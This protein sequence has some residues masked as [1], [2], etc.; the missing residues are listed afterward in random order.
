MEADSQ[1]CSNCKR[2]VAS[3]HF[4][5]HEAH[6]LRFLVLCPECE[7]PIPKSKMKE[8]AETVH[9][10]KQCPA[11]RT[12]K[13]LQNG[14][15]KILPPSLTSQVAGNQT[16]TVMTDVRPKTKIRN[17]STKRETKDQ[18][19]LMGLPLKPALQPRAAL[20]TGDAYDILQRCCRCD[21]LLPLPILNQHQE[22]CL[23][24]AQRETNK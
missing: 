2:D 4:T 12:V 21:I 10:Q 24:L 1:V 19:V 23:R 17:S 8:H 13:Y 14:K 9:Q 5:L 7:E 20:P 18:N 15:P 3:V 22:K 16:S 6:C 11:S